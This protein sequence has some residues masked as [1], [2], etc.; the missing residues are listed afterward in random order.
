MEYRL[1]YKKDYFLIII[2]NK[3]IF[4]QFIL[5]NNIILTYI[6]ILHIL[7]KFGLI[8]FKYI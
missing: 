3:N 8:S 5:N 4:R 6:Y 7:Y 1:I 2:N